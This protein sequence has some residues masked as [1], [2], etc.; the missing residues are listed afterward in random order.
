MSLS[1]SLSCSLWQWCWQ[2]FSKA[3]GQ[4]GYRHQ[5]SRGQVLQTTRFKCANNDYLQQELWVYF[6]GSTWWSWGETATW[7]RRPPSS[8]RAARHCS[9]PPSVKNVV[10]CSTI[11]APTPC[12]FICQFVSAWNI[13]FS[14]YIV[15]INVIK[16][17]WTF[18]S[19]C[20]I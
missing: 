12:A 6:K 13:V 9:S 15:R 2:V 7:W 16:N 8:P 4:L 1:L 5:V 14:H 3:G 17:D 10:G 11:T 18:A 20:L 19:S